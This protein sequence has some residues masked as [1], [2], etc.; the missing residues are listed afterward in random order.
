MRFWASYR[1]KG[2][3]WFRIFGYGLT[4]KDTHLF[5]KLFSERYRFSKFIMIG[6]WLIRGLKPVNY[7]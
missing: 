6:K 5:C 4:I 7:D 2:F 3:M 1:E